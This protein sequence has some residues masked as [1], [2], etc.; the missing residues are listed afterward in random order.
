M[1]TFFPGVHTLNKSSAVLVTA[2]RV[3]YLPTVVYGVS[4]AKSY[5]NDSALSLEVNEK[6]K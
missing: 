3:V 5:A 2:S 4:F 6:K 1:A